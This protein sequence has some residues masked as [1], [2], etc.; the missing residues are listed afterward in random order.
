MRVAVTS[1]GPF[2]PCFAS[3]LASRLPRNLRVLSDSICVQSAGLAPGSD[4]RA[5]GDVYAPPE[6]SGL[7][8]AS[9][10]WA[11]GLGASQKGPISPGV[12][13]NRLQE[14]VGVRASILRQIPSRSGR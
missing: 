12:H 1:A 10:S 13:P 3:P 11:A 5:A 14:P 9:T 4:V 7:L 2:C 8:P 6:A